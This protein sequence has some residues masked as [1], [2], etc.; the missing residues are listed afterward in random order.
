MAQPL[1][2]PG[3]GAARL[4]ERRCSNDLTRPAVC[5]TKH[6]FPSA[7]IGKRNA[8]IH[9][10]FEV[11]IVGCRFEFE[12]LPFRLGQQAGYLVMVRHV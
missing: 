2:K 11:E 6:D 8:I 1:I 5:Y 7:F 3:F 4:R 9:Q 10:F 12:P